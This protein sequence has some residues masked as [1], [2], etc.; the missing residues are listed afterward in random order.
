MKFRHTRHTW[1]GYVEFHCYLETLDFAKRR[2]VGASMHFIL[3]FTQRSIK[4]IHLI[5]RG[6]I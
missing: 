3:L 6:S 5:H 1:P 4:A 2:T